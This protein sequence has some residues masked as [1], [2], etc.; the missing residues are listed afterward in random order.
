MCVCSSQD[1]FAV[2][3]AVKVPVLARDWVIHPLQIAEVYKGGGGALSSIVST[4]RIYF[5]RVLVFGLDKNWE[6]RK[7][8][9]EGTMGMGVGL[10]ALI[11]VWWW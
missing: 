4:V 9:K 6:R 3:R 2:T 5:L 1:L 8:R 7:S 11:C 10:I